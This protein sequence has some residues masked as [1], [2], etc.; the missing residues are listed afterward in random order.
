M[1]IQ[2]GRSQLFGIWFG[3]AVVA[4]PEIGKTCYVSST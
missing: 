2:S 1:A 3:E 4:E